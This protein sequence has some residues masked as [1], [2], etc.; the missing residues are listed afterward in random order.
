MKV[1]Y[2]A[3]HLTLLDTEADLVEEE[4]TTILLDCVH[5][6]AGEVTDPATMQPSAFNLPLAKVQI[7]QGVLRKLK[8]KN[9]FFNNVKEQAPGRN[10]EVG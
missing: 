3:F 4:L 9:L 6:D 10:D 8:N 1:Q 7:I 5:K 2:A